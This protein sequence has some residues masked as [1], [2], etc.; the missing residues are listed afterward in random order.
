MSNDSSL[1]PDEEAGLRW[2]LGTPDPIV[3]AMLA[4]G[5]LPMIAIV[6]AWRDAAA[7][8]EPDEP[9]PDE[10]DLHSSLERL[11]A[12]GY[13]SQARGEYALTRTGAELADQVDSLYRA[14]RGDASADAGGGTAGS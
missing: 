3:C 5:P 1:G 12:A 13:V 4:A 2:L 9:H 7:W 11:S 10:D 6:R 8:S 14:L